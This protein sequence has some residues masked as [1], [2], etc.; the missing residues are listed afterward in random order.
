[1]PQNM[2]SRGPECRDG[3]ANRDVV[4]WSVCV[5]VA[6]I[7]DLTACRA[8]DTVYLGVCQRLQGRHTQLLR[9]RV[10]ARMLEQLISRIV[11][12]G[13][14]GIWLQAAARSVNSPW[15]ILSSILEL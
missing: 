2:A 14:T 4:P 13:N 12:V 8:A 9:Q 5:H 10:D 7:S 1:M 11:N 15:E 6:G 3:L